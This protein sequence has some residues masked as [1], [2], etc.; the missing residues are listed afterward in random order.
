MSINTVDLTSYVEK[1]KKV[2]DKIP[3]VHE[4]MMTNWER[5]ILVSLAEAFET[6]KG[7]F[8]FGTWRGLTTQVLAVTTGR[9]IYTLDCPHLREGFDNYNAY[10]G[11]EA[12]PVD[13]IG[14]EFKG[15]SNVKQ[16]LMDSIRFDPE[17]EGLL[18]AMDLILVD[19][20]HTYKYIES[21]FNN[22]MKMLRVGGIMVLHDFVTILTPGITLADN[23]SADVCNFVHATATKYTWIHVK[24]TTLVF[25]IKLA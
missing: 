22:G 15:A 7:I 3:Y 18:G 1:F 25:T 4:Q 6:S 11:F 2:V 5:K 8:E 24:D 19:G 21:D 10:Q 13:E 23:Q 12:L 14:M 16:Y 17:K 20:N 9:Q